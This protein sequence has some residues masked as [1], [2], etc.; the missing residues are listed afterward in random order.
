MSDG[1]IPRGNARADDLD[2][3]H[4]RSGTRP[5]DSRG[6]TKTAP[7]V[8]SGYQLLWDGEMRMTLDVYRDML[9]ALGA[10]LAAVYFLLVAYYRSFMIPFIAMSAVPLGIT[11]S[12]PVTGCWAPT[13][14]RPRSLVSSRY[15]AS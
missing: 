11:G 13:S 4:V 10:A 14:R 12:S 1:G 3:G 15:P 6:R 5:L 7:D 9:A 2:L 8:I